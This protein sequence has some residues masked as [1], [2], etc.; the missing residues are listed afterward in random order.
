MWPGLNSEIIPHE[1]ESWVEWHKNETWSLIH[2]V[3][4]TLKRILT[5]PLILLPAL[6]ELSWFL[7]S[8]AWLNSFFDSISYLTLLQWIWFLN[9]P[10]CLPA[11]ILTTGN[12]NI[13]SMQL[14][15]KA[16]GE[17][18]L[19]HWLISSH[20]IWLGFIHSFIQLYTLWSLHLW[21]IYHFLSTKEIL[22]KYLHG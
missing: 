16:C 8:K 5:D 12:R 13:S 15:W 19:L 3:N 21:T 4:G 20:Y 1:F 11:N 17:T 6:C 14:I 10:G 9:C 2:F 18:M 22:F 7:L